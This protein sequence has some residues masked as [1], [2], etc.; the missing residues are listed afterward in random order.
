[1][2]ELTDNSNFSIDLSREEV[3]MYTNILNEILNGIDVRDLERQLGA[4]RE[5][6]ELLLRRFNDAYEGSVGLERQTIS[7]HPEDVR[8]LKEGFLI[9]IRELGEE[10]MSPR[11]GFTMPEAKRHFLALENLLRDS[12]IGGLT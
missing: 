5:A 11:T 9:C 6:L 2:S 7:L 8:T 3:G 4:S 12:L 1:M 10:E